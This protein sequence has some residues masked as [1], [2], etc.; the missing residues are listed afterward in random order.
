MNRPMIAALVLTPVVAM[1]LSLSGVGAIG[2]HSN[3]SACTT[4]TTPKTK[5]VWANADH[6]KK[7]RVDVYALVK[8]NALIDGYKDNVYVE[9]LEYT[10]A[11]FCTPPKSAVQPVT[12]TLPGA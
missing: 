3:S 9:V 11:T 7:A 4:K 10:R 2:V 5:L 6:T 12:T 1:S 8:E